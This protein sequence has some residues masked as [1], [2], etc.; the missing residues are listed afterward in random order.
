MLIKMHDIQL[1]QNMERDHKKPFDEI[2]F[3]KF[4]IEKNHPD[5][6]SNTDARWGALC[7]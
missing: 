2:F 7:L 3:L 1:I 6:V 5:K 4:N